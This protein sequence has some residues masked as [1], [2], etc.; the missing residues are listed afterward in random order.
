MGALSDKSV[1]K[2][3]T[4]N[5][6]ST[7]KK[8]GTFTIIS[9]VSTEILNSQLK[10]RLILKNPNNKLRSFDIKVGG[11]VAVYFCTADGLVIHAIAGPIPAKEFLIEAKW[12]VTTYK[13]A[14]ESS[15]EDENQ[16]MKVIRKAH[17]SRISE[18]NKEAKEKMQIG[19]KDKKHLRQVSWTLL[20]HQRNPLGVKIHELFSSKAMKHVDEVYKDVFVGLL[21]QQVSNKDIQVQKEFE[22]HVKKQMTSDV[23]K[24]LPISEKIK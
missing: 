9:K 13:S 23:F 1:G 11:N 21:R 19:I 22:L 7:W 8:V 15:Q 2:F 24:R 6:I 10:D 4:E 5:Y 20:N 16:L 14:V 12:A 18:I 3:I 17:K